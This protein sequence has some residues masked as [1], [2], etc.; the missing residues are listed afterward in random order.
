[1]DKSYLKRHPFSDMSEKELDNAIQYCLN[2]IEVAIIERNF[3]SRLIKNYGKTL[4][5]LEKEKESRC[6]LH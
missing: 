1:M 6:N 4:I 5:K 2:N 3:E